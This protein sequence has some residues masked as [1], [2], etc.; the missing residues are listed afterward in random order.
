MARRHR[1]ALQVTDQRQ[2]LLEPVEDVAA[3][4]LHMIEIELDAHVG[5][6]DLADDVG[7]VLDVV[8]EVAGPVA[9]IDRL[10]Q[11]FD[12]PGRGEVGSAGD[13]RDIDALGR[14]TLLGRHVP[15][16]AM[17]RAAADRADVIERLGKR[18]LPVLLAAGQR[19]KAEL[20]LAASA[21]RIDAEDG[22]AVADDLRL[23]RRRRHLVGKLQLDALEAGDG[24][25]GDTLQHRAFGE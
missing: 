18:R 25:G 20:A 13:I 9:R 21:R 23:H 19:R 2:I 14:R 15:G 6:A 3:D 7:G 4:D 12:V 8:E 11:D 10:H 24:G 1:G 22:E 5:L 17:H 16:Q